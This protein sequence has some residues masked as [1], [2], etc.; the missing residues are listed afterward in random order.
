MLIKTI[1][2]IEISGF[3]APFT[4]NEK[5]LFKEG[6]C[7]Q[8]KFAFTC[9]L[10]PGVYFLNAGVL[11]RENGEDTFLDRWLDAAMFRVRYKRDACV[12]ASVDLVDNSEIC[13][14]EG[15]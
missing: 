8:V 14:I 11:S 10:N 1:K 5:H 7:W 6:T 3:S 12:T 2:G 9:R 4:D 13:Q 15:V